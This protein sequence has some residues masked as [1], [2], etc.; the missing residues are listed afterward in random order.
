[1]E[2]SSLKRKLRSLDIQIRS[3]PLHSVSTTLD[4]VS[5]AKEL[6]T[7]AGDETSDRVRHDVDCITGILR[8]RKNR[9]SDVMDHVGYVFVTTNGKTNN[10]AS[11]WYKD[12]D[13]H[14]IPPM[15]HYLL[16]SNLAWLKRPASASKLKV[17]ELVAL[18]VAALRPTRKKWESFTSELKKLKDSGEITSDEIAVTVASSLTD[19]LLSDPVAEDDP[20]AESVKEIVDRVKRELTSEAESKLEDA[21][22]SQAQSVADRRQLEMRLDE[23]ARSVGRTVSWAIV[24]VLAV[25]LA[26]SIIATSFG[27]VGPVPIIGFVAFLAISSLLGTVFGS[28]LKGWRPAIE[29]RVTTRV[30]Q[31]FVKDSSLN[32]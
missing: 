30:R 17:H 5:L 1:M 12:E 22:L 27:G 24:I 18:C 28:N 15:V 6:S 3:L 14:G 4:E 7:E 23:R 20:D 21:R 10:S 25:I 32:T 11:K 31:W 29:S 9:K 16:L 8:L 2:A 19:E 26:F 13:G